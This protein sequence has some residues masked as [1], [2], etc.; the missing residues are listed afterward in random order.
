MV[1]S[2]YL[3]FFLY[4]CCMMAIFLS[5]VFIAVGR[6]SGDVLFNRDFE[7]GSLIFFGAVK[8]RD[9]H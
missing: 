9:S 5:F 6:V 7:K 1:G 4:E 2:N 8:I 3:S